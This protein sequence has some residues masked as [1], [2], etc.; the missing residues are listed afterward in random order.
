M[1][2]AHLRPKGERKSKAFFNGKSAKSKEYQEVEDLL[3]LIICDI[4]N[5]IQRSD[6]IKKLQEGLYE[7][8]TKKYALSSAQK[9]YWT[10]TQRI[11]E[12][13][14]T[15]IENLKDTLYSQYYSLFADAVSSN[16]TFVAKQILDSI[17]KVFVDKSDKKNVDVQVV[18][19]KEGIT[20][21]FGFQDNDE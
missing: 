19:N 11:K 13:R 18:N 6:I 5:G 21:N 8:Q 20:I 17:A 10:A 1:L 9:Y 15:D 7:G 3:A 12:D 16:N 4:V 14:E 2:D